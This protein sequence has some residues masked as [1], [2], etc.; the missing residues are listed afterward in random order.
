MLFD[1]V[2]GIDGYA[3][4]NSNGARRLSPLAAEELI[5]HRCHVDGCFLLRVVPGIATHREFG[6][7][8]PLQE[9]VARG[10]FGERLH[11]ELADDDEHRRA[12]AAHLVE[13]ALLH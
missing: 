1:V 6:V 7:R 9:G 10:G 4:L 8:I 11:V 2:E 3:S 12:V 13:E 5:D